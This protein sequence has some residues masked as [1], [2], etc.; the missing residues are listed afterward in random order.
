VKDEITLKE[1]AW[2]PNG[3]RWWSSISTK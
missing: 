2:I 3:V 1:D